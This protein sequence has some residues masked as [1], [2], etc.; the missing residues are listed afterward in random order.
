MRK[1]ACVFA[2]LFALACCASAQARWTTPRVLARGDFS[3]LHVAGNGRDEVAIVWRDDLPDGSNVLLFAREF[4]GGRVFEPPAYLAGTE[5]ARDV[6][7]AVDENRQVV[8][9]WDWFDNTR[10]PQPGIPAGTEC[11]LQVRAMTTDQVGETPVA[12][13]TSGAGGQL[14]GLAVSRAGLAVAWR[15]GGALWAKVGPRVGKLGA[16]QKISGQALGTVAMRLHGAATSFAYTAPGP[17]L[18]ERERAADGRLSAE[19]PLLRAPL[20]EHLDFSNSQLGFT[21]D[22]SVVGSFGSGNSRHGARLNALVAPP[23]GRARI[24][25]IYR[26]PRQFFDRPA[27]ATSSSGAALVAASNGRLVAAYRPPGG[28]FGRA[29]VLDPHPVLHGP[30]PVAAVGPD[31]R[32]IVAWYGG[33][34]FEVSTSTADGRFTRPVGIAAPKTPEQMAAVVDH[35]GRAVIVWLE[36]GRLLAARSRIG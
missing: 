11:C 27:F 22:G 16:A 28:R 36:Q 10:P 7:V 9:A 4:E 19:R 15:A 18:V 5:D 21:G 33:H 6:R 3:D 17:S 25:A 31:G 30:G 14:A 1:S 23:A 24:D 20:V 2:F 13:L 29:R 32:G 35:R 26:S 34:G 8:I 12:R